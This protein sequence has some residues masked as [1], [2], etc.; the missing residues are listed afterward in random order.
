MDNFT[1]T[2]ELSN[3]KLNKNLA[4]HTRARAHAHARKSVIK[5]T[6][7]GNKTFNNKRRNTFETR[8]PTSEREERIKKKIC[9]TRKLV[10]GGGP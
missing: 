8:H 3:N 4:Y 7:V 1:N 2:K 5:Q 6:K 10:G 9:S